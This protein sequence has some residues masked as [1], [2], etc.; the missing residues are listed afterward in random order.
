MYMTGDSGVGKTS[1]LC[2]YTDGQFTGKYTSTVG[3]D[4]REKRIVSKR[5][6]EVYLMYFRSLKKCIF[7]DSN[8]L[9]K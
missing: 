3:V 6:L 9:I 7:T 1:F 4:F 2:Q 8:E 5:I